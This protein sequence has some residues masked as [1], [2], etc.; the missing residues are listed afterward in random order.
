MNPFEELG[1]EAGVRTLVDRFYENMDSAADAA[2]IREMHQPDL[3]E[4]RE[5]L[6]LFLCGWLGGPQLHF[7]RYGSFCMRTAHAPFPIDAA[8]RDAWVGCML[9]ALRASPL[10][11]STRDAL[12]EAFGR[13][14]AML[15]NS[16]PATAS[17]PRVRP[18]D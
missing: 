14:A 16:E 11:E 4:M 7:E 3:G 2:V 10:E 13:T 5:R 8:A 6:S 12:T 18:G 17:T 1:G 15:V 9:E